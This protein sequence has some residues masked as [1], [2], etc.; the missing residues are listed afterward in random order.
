MLEL[1]AI[2]SWTYHG[3]TNLCGAWPPIDAA[4]SGALGNLTD[5][6]LCRVWRHVHAGV[7]GL[8][9]A[10]NHDVA[11]AIRTAQI[12]ALQLLLV[13]YAAQ[14]QQAPFLPIARRFCDGALSR[15]APTAPTPPSVGDTPHRL[16]D[17]ALA[18]PETDGSGAAR[19]R[20]L[21][22]G[23]A[24][25][26]LEELEH[27]LAG[28]RFPVTLPPAFR[29]LVLPDAAGHSRLVARFGEQ[30]TK[31][32]KD[33]AP[34]RHILTY[35]QL[36]RIE[37]MGANVEALLRGVSQ[38]VSDLTAITQ[39]GFAQ[40]RREIARDKGLDP[41]RLRPMFEH[42]GMDNLSE[43]EMLEKAE[44]GIAALIGRAAQPAPASNAGAD[45]AAT[46]D[47]ARARMKDVDSAGALALLARQVAEEDA[48]R[49]QL[50]E[51]DAARRQR[52]LPLLEE[53]VFVQRAT[54]DRP[55]AIT[56]LTRI[57][58]LD[59]DR[60]WTWFD[61]GDL[62]VEAGSLREAEAAYRAGAAAARRL[63]A[64]DPDNAGWQRDLSVS[65][66]RIGDVQQ[67]QGDLAAALTSY[68]AGLVIAKRL[69]QADP[70]NAGW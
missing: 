2:A 3:L 35:G 15:C 49:R 8:Q 40:L 7:R 30:L 38:Q 12:E 64:A 14:D 22:A 68:R 66:N 6:E 1:V 48:G 5:R 42:L 18:A 17:E 24:Q 23:I 11:R 51:Q 34:F 16:I 44:A 39:D 53:Q 10:L 65:H 46:I 60:P 57:A 27:E 28:G 31:Q 61:I 13:D 43:A 55:G 25:A 37:H 26:L 52:L 70:G 62:R 58:E 20:A 63:L 36:S 54:Y 41:A 56:T 21:T 45:I 4:L 67:A 19:A 69:A 32:I 9:P 59:P 47:A 29:A 50:A 33:N